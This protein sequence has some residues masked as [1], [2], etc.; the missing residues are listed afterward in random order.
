[1]VTHLYVKAKL[2]PQALCLTEWCWCE[3]L[4]SCGLVLCVVE[5]DKGYAVAAQE[6]ATGGGMVRSRMQPWI[7][8]KTKEKDQK[9]Q[10]LCKSLN[11]R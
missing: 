1:M 2:P 4:L 8:A 6:A 10:Q 5:K 9:W 3:I 7:Q 11:K